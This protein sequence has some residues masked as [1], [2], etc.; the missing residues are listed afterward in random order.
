MV[1]LL[2]FLLLQSPLSQMDDLLGRYFS[3]LLFESDSAKCAEVDWIIES[4][5][6]S[7]LRS[8]VAA[9]IFR[10]Y[11]ES[12]LMGE[13]AVALHV[14][15]RWY[16]DATI[17][18]EDEAESYEAALFATF[19]RQSMIGLPAPVLEL[20]RPDGSP[21]RLPDEGR[22]SVVFFYETGCPKCKAMG[23][24]LPYVMEDYPGSTIYAVYTGSSEEQW[25]EFR[26][27]FKVMNPEVKVEHLWD[28][29]V[30]SG[31][32]MAYGVTTTPRLYAISPA[33]SIVGRRLEID[34]LKELLRISQPSPQRCSSGWS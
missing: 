18:F 24:L 19:N 11:R 28:P 27:G 9:K 7:T 16:A 14:W 31:Y 17:V 6:D 13:E 12:P 26:E 2:L 15:D 3:A 23:I 33:G 30:E 21:C 8:D 4:C 10:H 34:N 1:K 20:R 29:E 5:K 32:Q 25:A 22:F